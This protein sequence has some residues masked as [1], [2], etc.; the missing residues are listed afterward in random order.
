MPSSIRA[1][2]VNHWM[3]DVP[4]EAVQELAVTLEPA[5]GSTTGHGADPKAGVKL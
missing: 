4:L 3:G 1:A 5:G 2:T